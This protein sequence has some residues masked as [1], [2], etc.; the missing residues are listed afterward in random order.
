MVF[1]LLTVLTGI[2]YPLMVTGVAQLFIPEKANGSLIRRGGGYAGSELI[3]QPFDDPKYFW[4]RLSATPD[5]PYNSASSSGSNFGPS[6]PGL[7]KA[8]KER[9]DALQKADPGNRS[10]VPIDLVTSSGSGLDPH[11]SPAAA[12]YQVP[13]VARARGL[14]EEEVNHL[15][16][17]LTEPRQL[18]FLGEPRINV[19]KLNLALD[20]LQR[21]GK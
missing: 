9:I 12:F 5:F 10:S 4:G 18:G 11:I 3:G 16:A 14:S 13:R 7:V 20:G 15:V 17:L 21:P 8:A 6:N 1:L 19:L 2:V